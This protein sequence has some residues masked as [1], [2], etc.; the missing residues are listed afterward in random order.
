VT[1][2]AGY[3]V[4]RGQ[5]LRRF[6]QKVAPPNEEGCLLWTGAIDSN[7]YGTFRS[8]EGKVVKAHRWI[9]ERAVGPIPAGLVGDHECHNRSLTCRGGPTCQHRRCVNVEHQKPKTFT[10]NVQA[11]RAGA[12]ESEK[13]HCPAQHPYAQF[14]VSYPSSKGKRECRE[15]KRLRAAAFYAARR[16]ERMV[17]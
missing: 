9:Y 2:Q 16:A 3:K 8:P 1:S 6:W 10:E 17:D 12:H 4:F 14:G 7:G 13:T 5:P 11:G 15:C